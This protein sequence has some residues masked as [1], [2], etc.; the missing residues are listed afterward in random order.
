MAIITVLSEILCEVDME[1]FKSYEIW[2]IVGAALLIILYYY[3]REKKKVH[4]AKEK[5]LLK[6]GDM[7]ECFWEVLSG[8]YF[9]VLFFFMSLGNITG[10]AY[11]FPVAIAV[12]L[13]IAI[14]MQVKIY[15]CKEELVSR[16]GWSYE[17]AVLEKK[18]NILESAYNIVY[19][20]IVPITILFI[21]YGTCS[22]YY[23]VPKSFCILLF[24]IIVITV[25]AIMQCKR[26]NYK[27]KMRKY[28]M[29]K[30]EGLC[31]EELQ[32]DKK[33]SLRELVYYCTEPEPV[34]ALMFT[35]EWGCGKTYLI[36]HELKATFD[37]QNG[38]EEKVI[39]RVSLFGV[40]SVENI[41]SLVKESWM[42]AYY[43]NFPTVLKKTTRFLKNI[44]SS[45]AKMEGN[46]EMKLLASVG[47]SNFM[48][49]KNIINKKP[50]ILVFDDLERC[51]MD[52][53]DVLGCINDYCENQK[54]YTIIVCNPDKMQSDKE[55]NEEDKAKDELIQLTY[56]EIKEKIVQRTVQYKPDYEGI[57]HN[58]IRE[59]KYQ[60]KEYQGFIEK[61][62]RELLELFAPNMGVRSTGENVQLHN[63]RSLK[64]AITDFYRIYIIL[65]KNGFSDVE[66]WLYAFTRYVIAYKAGVKAD[67]N[68]NYMLKA[69]EEWLLHGNWDEEQLQYEIKERIEREKAKK[70]TDL[71]RVNR[72]MDLDEEDVNNGFP[73]LIELAYSG[74]LTLDEYVNLIQNSVCGQGNISSN[75]QIR[76][77][78]EKYEKE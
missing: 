33:S 61:H 26:F 57:V 68:R 48:R 50:V 52:R 27:K 14:V 24:A 67:F 53:I 29:A 4:N 20:V 63:I 5:E 41:H 30:K 13:V 62:E 42:E 6:K 1:I 36:D 10:L 28:Q 19:A 47:L 44:Q 22:S 38:R 32:I 18:K 60:D 45:I 58:V 43:E 16:S 55:R 69:I 2:M 17:E 15:V 31:M 35:G 23:S 71:L 39:I 40:S 3:H 8:G 9:P 11:L 34:G 76:L 46:D 77:S 54:F 66:R 25:A 74:K 59:L 37:G 49:V 72:I 7:H 70:P 75:F 56:A 21:S 51:Q 64:C 78:G 65:E 12:V 73:E